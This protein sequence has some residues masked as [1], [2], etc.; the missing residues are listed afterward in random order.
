MGFWTRTEDQPVALRPLEERDS[1]KLF[2]WIN[3]PELVRMSSAY[4][5]VTRADHEQW[6][7]GAR[8]AQA[9]AIERADGRM[10]GFCQLLP[11][12]DRRRAELRIR[13]GDRQSW[14][15]GIGTK[16]TRLLVSHGFDRL[17]LE[18]IELRVFAENRAA[19][20]VYEKVGFAEC[21]RERVQVEGRE[22]EIISMILRR[23]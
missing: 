19:R 14:G 21:G 18:T 6:F 13:I 22:R 23:R 11:S 7:R 15:Q 8:Q 20:A 2:E 9:F 10:V 5:P 12:E 16:A 4:R 17:Q 3:D 1:E